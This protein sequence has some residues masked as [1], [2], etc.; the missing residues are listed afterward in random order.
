M[1]LNNYIIFNDKL[2]ICSE[3][4]GL[5]S[6]KM[7]WMMFCFST[8]AAARSSAR[9]PAA[10]SR[11]LWSLWVRGCV[12]ARW[13]CER[14]GGGAARGCVGARCG[15]FLWGWRRTAYGLTWEKS[16]QQGIIIKGDVKTTSPTLILIK[17]FYLCLSIHV[18][19]YFCDYCCVAIACSQ[20]QCRMAV[21]V[22][23]VYISAC[24]D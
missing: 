18:L 13:K 24:S 21:G 8:W 1:Y 9:W 3:S 22:W 11:L 15:C 7:S 6:R 20:L 23:S 14:C 10:C 12:G 2:S 16:E 4:W 17:N 5:H 19:L